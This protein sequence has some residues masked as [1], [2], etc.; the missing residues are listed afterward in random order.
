MDGG[1]CH[2]DVGLSQ[3]GAEA[4]PKGLA[5]R[6]LK[7]YVSWVQS[8]VKQLGHYLLWVLENWNDM[9]LVREDR[10]VLTSSAPVVAPAAQLGSYV[11]KG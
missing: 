7:R 8:V 9:F 6:Q 2:F 4:G 10:N 5:V 11:G 3:P 1:V